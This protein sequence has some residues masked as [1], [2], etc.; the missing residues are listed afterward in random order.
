M[1]LIEVQ[2]TNQVSASIRLDETTARQVDQYAAM[3]KS[4]ADEVV[5]AS[6]VHVFSKCKDFQEFLKSPQSRQV[7]SS[8]RIRKTTSQEVAEPAPKKPVAAAE[9]PASTQAKAV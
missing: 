3:I 9:A 1:P 6:L 8:L 4:D 7:P 2:Q 5:N